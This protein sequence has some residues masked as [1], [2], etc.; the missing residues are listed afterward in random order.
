M[1][2]KNFLINLCTERVENN[3]PQPTSNL[4]LFMFPLILYCS[5][6]LINIYKQMFCGDQLLSLIGSHSI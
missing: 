4:V 5:T 6:Q 1:E 3:F 2:R